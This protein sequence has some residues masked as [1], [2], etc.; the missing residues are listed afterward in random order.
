MKSDIELSRVI[1]HALRHMPDEYGLK[2]DREGW[3]NLKDL[4]EAL[5]AKSNDFLDLNERDVYLMIE[6]SV[7]RRHE[8]NGEKIRAVYGHSVEVE[9]KYAEKI[10]P[11]KLY[12]GTSREAGKIILHEGL[13][14]MS[15]QYVHL[16]SAIS[17][18]LEVGKRKDAD[19]II[20]EIEAYSASTRGIR[21]YL[22][23][24]VWLSEFISAEFIRVKDGA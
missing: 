4:I 10:P 6:R 13:A 14:P 21:F 23:D 7:K 3:V 20:L 18:A 15:R 19:P 2:I 11:L 24:N 5:K 8:V 12:H 9:I 22:L 17:N 1:S 16:T